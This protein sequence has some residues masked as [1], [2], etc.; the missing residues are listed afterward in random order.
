M[1]DEER[2]RVNDA[3]H[4]DM[5]KRIG[6]LLECEVQYDFFQNVVESGAIDIRRDWGLVR[7]V[8]GRY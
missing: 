5:L 6:N 4:G 3:I 1:T 2:Q 7:M 8:S